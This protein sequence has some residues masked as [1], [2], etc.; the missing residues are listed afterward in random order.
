M[1]LQQ[2][3]PPVKGEIDAALIS[4]AGERLT[5]AS[6]HFAPGSTT[7]IAYFELAN[8]YN[9]DQSAGSQGSLGQIAMSQQPY[10]ETDSKD[11]HGDTNADKQVP[12]RPST[13]VEFIEQSKDWFEPGRYFK[14]WAPGEP[15][16]HN[17]YF[18]LLNSKNIQGKGVLVV[19]LDEKKLQQLQSSSS[20]IHTHIALRGSTSS[21]SEANAQNL[22]RFKTAY[23]EED[24]RHDVPPNTFVALGYAY[25]IAFEY[26][27]KDYGKLDRRNIRM[28]RFYYVQNLIRDLDLEEEMRDHYSV[29]NAR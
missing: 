28:L 12:P 2:Q 18:I 1:S 7:T 20:T 25:N 22:K 5:S 8:Q 15:Q 27:C 9:F 6:F 13:P 17:K 4:K 19:S 3:H 16:I 14:I 23:V 11:P 29:S 24:A 26:K 10:P 21:G